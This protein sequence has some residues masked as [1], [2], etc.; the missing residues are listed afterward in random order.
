MK[1]P[2]RLKT[3]E[4]VGRRRTIEDVT[5]LPEPFLRGGKR[6]IEREIQDFVSFLEER[7]KSI[8]ADE[9]GAT[10]DEDFQSSGRLTAIE[11]WMAAAIN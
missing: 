11:H 2:L 10:G 6:R 8:G 5:L 3:T 7:F 1:H 4:S 9:T